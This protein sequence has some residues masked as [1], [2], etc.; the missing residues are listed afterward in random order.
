MALHGYMP[1]GHR[2]ILF[3]LSANGVPLGPNRELIFGWTLARG[4]RPM[5]TP[6]GI[7]QAPN[8][9]LFVTEDGNGTLLRIS[10]RPE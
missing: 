7:A 6:V 3:P 2:V 4:I 10:R 1:A 8:G 9:A 5:G